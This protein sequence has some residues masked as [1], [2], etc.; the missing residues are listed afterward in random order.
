MIMARVIFKFSKTLVL[1]YLIYGYL[2][3]PFL[4][5]EIKN[6]ER[7]TSRVQRSRIF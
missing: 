3:D 5:K 4:G 1:V 2:C 7:F 6:E